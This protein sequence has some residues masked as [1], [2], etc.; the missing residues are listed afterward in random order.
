MTGFWNPAAS[1]W[2]RFGRIHAQSDLLDLRWSR[3][4]FFSANSELEAGSEAPNQALKPCDVVVYRNVASEPLVPIANV[5]FAFAG[6]RPNWW[7][8]AYDD[9]LSL[10][11]PEAATGA[12]LALVVFNRDRF[13]GDDQSFETWL[14]ER[15]DRLSRRHGNQAIAVVFDQQHSRRLHFFVGSVLVDEILAPVGQEFIDPRLEKLTGSP[16]TAL[17]WMHVAR[18]L[19]TRLAYRLVAGPK[20][21]LIVDMD[22]TLHD[23][24]VGD[25]GLGVQVSD[26]HKSLQHELREARSKGYL[27]ALLSKNDL[28]DVMQVLEKHPDYQLRPDDFLAIDASWDEKAIGMQRILDRARVGSDSVIFIDDNPAELLSVGDAW[29]QVALVNAGDGPEH[30]LRNLRF[31]PGYFV[32][33]DDHAAAGRLDDL[34]ANAVREELLRTDGNAYVREARPVL[35]VR[36]NDEEDLTRLV[37]LG[38]R[39][40]QFNLLLKRLK[41]DGYQQPNCNFAALSLRDRFSDSGVIGGLLVVP[42]ADSE[43]GVVS[44]L[45]LS[46]RVLGRQLET[47]M[48]MSALRRILDGGHLDGAWLEWTVAERNQPALSWLKTLST[49]IDVSGPGRMFISRER[50]ENL[51]Q[52]PE[53]VECEYI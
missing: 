12:Q 49:E 39:S 41:K 2:S 17:A 30:T 13:N 28:I 10:G 19:A 35:S 37:D 47:P 1:P 31:C 36:L 22:Y 26:A 23:G 20:K 38:G 48:I 25:Y 42:K 18:N 15:I 33:G 4:D 8:A 24:V 27:L 44:E 14:G 5:F 9:S 51:S 50:I 53:G 34:R 3:V 11:P 16:L 52:I 45:F 32:H 29:P 7:F 46:C 40:N 6:L 21:I 43:E